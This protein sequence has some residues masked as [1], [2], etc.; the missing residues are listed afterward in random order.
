VKKSPLKSIGFG[1]ISESVHGVGY[2]L[3]LQLIVDSEHC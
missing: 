3:R 1:N 2:V